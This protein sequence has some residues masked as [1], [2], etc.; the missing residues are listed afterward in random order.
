MDTR[1]IAHIVRRANRSEVARRTDISLSGISR[2]LSGDRAASSRNL[3]RIAI[4]L[5]IPMGELYTHL[6][7]LQ[8][9]KAHRRNRSGVAA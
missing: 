6:N 2:I 9:R 4:H 1:E 3:A 7:R 5:G 8:R